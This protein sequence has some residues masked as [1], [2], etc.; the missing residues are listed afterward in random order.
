LL[1]KTE[2][3]LLDADPWRAVEAIAAELIKSQTISGRAA[4]HLYEQSLKEADR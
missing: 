1:S 3:H 2:H 4:K